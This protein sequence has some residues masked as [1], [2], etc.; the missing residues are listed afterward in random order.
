MLNW[1]TERRSG[2]T[3]RYVVDV[4][5]L[6]DLVSGFDRVAV[7]LHGREHT[8]DRDGVLRL[9]ECEREAGNPSLACIDAAKVEYDHKLDAMREFDRGLRA[10][11]GEAR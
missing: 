5:R 6:A 2:S 4:D 9:L 10:G 7:R 11:R 1:L 8:Y 3:L